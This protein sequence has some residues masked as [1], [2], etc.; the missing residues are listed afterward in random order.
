MLL[1][2][3]RQVFI[4]LPK[5]KLIVMT[6]RTYLTPIDKIK[7]EGNA[8][9]LIRGIDSLPEDLAFYKKEECGAKP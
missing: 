8:K 4:R 7:Q 5:T 1:R 6:I 3:E 9:E 2:C